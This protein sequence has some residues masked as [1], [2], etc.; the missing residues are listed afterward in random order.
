MATLGARHHR[1]NRQGEDAGLWLFDENGKLLPKVVEI[2]DLVR[3][4]DALLCTGHISPRESL[5]LIRLARGRGLARVLVTHPD[6]LSVGMSV[7]EQ[8][9]AARLGAMLERADVITIAAHGLR[10]NRVPLERMA[11]AIRGGRGGE[12]ALVRPRTG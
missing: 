5:A 11:E 8:I 7:D 4:A 9:E 3:D 12:R 6:V 10:D 1:R 2:L